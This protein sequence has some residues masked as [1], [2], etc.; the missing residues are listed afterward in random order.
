MKR[1]DFFTKLGLGA[2]AAVVAPQIVKAVEPEIKSNIAPKESYPATPDGGQETWD[3]AY[4]QYPLTYDEAYRDF[5]EYTPIYGG[6]TYVN[7]DRKPWSMDDFNELKD[8]ARFVGSTSFITTLLC[9][10][11]QYMWIENLLLEYIRA[12]HEGKPEGDYGDIRVFAK[13]GITYNLLLVNDLDPYS[14]IILPHKT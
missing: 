7:V 12:W 4:R 13:N 8:Y 2:V 9:G 6:A 1:R 5:N 14:M 11:Q 3:K 10:K